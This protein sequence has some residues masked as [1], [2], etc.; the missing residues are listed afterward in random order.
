MYQLECPTTTH[1]KECIFNA[2]RRPA[3]ALQNTTSAYLSRKNKKKTTE[4]RPRMNR[5]AL[6]HMYH[7]KQSQN[8]W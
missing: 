4:N 6:Y 3:D 2:V 1:P 8:M 5:S 7:D